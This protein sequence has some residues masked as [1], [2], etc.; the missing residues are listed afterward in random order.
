MVSIGLYFARNFQKRSEDNAMIAAPIGVE[1]A[2]DMMISKQ[3]IKPSLE[4]L[5]LLAH[6]SATKGNPSAPIVPPRI[7]V[8]N[9]PEARISPSL[10]TAI[11][12]AP[13]VE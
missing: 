5:L 10:K 8:P 6:A 1:D 12:L 13:S 2:E 11:G 7:G 9:G 4:S 3:A